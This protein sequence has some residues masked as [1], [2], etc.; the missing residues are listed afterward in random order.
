MLKTLAAA[1]R[2]E[3]TAFKIPRSVQ[4][5]IPIQRVY[6]DGIWQVNGK[7][8]QTWRFADINYTLASYEDQK[9]MFS[10]YC[11]VLN[12]LPTDA[13]TKITI[14][15][16]RLNSTDFHKTVLMR[17]Q[18][19][20]LNLYRRE[21]NAVLMD[22]AAGSNNLVQDKYITICAA[23]K[24]VEEA[25][26]FFRRVDADLTKN[27]G[28][29]DSGA[30]VLDTHERL[31]IL[32]GF[33]RPG[34][35]QYYSFDLGNAM[36]LGHDFRDYICPDGMRF[37]SDHFEMGGR[38]GR[39]LF[40]RDYPSYIKDTLISELS[41]FPR[42]LMLSI[43]ILPIPTAE[44]VRDM[45]QRIMGVESDITRWQ[46]RQNN[47]N[48]FTAAIPYELEQLRAENREFLDDLSAR[49]QRMIHGNITL[50]H[51]ADTLEQLN[52]DTEALQSIGQ[53]RACQ[54]SVLRYQQEDGLNTALPYGLRPITTTRTLTTESAAVLMPFRVQEIQDAGGIYCGVNAVSQNLLI[55]NRK[56]LLNPHGFILGVSGSGKS[57][58]MKQA[59]TF[60]ALS[61]NDDIIIIDA[62]REVRHEVA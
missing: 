44:A 3:R 35:E 43:D 45:Q 60:I 49:D 24:N 18:G 27:L 30:R 58:S 53:E 31:R 51:L 22:K 25:R 29:L 12:S 46:Q 21:Y 23:R 13:T 52:A 5:T 62:E 7:F 11:A 56:Q 57:F 61:T 1:N 28:Q 54:F 40:L 37:R 41:D 36:R 20:G 33:F 9:E 50:V 48:N 14:N 26:I 34:E 47:R 55:C 15:N 42:N 10:S 59:I 4:Q 39:V 17:E 38:F 16:R 2:S 6:R 8:S 32:H 19:D